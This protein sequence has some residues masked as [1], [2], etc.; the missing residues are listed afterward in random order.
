MGTIVIN[1]QKGGVGKTTIALHLAWYL[2]EQGG[3]VLVIDLDAQGNATSTLTPADAGKG[4]NSWSALALGEAA[5]L[6]LEP[7]APIERAAP[8]L[9]LFSASGRLTGIEG[10][11]QTALSRFRSNFVSL[12][13]AFD[14][15]IIDTP[16]SWGARNLGA[17]LVCDHLIAPIQLEDYALSGVNSLLKTIVIADK[18][19]D[20]KIRFLG[21]LPSQFRANSTLHKA[22]LARI[23]EQLGRTDLLFPG[24]LGLRQGYAEAASRAMPVWALRDK[25]AAVVAGREMRHVLRAIH[26]KLES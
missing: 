26:L 14:H 10:Q 21:L 20:T 12:A 25:T 8:G 22:N 13:N 15:I 2:A 3:S 18:A 17:L 24:Y 7:P 16:P 19:R 4:G 5:A 23:V 9:Y 1:N 6:F 11:L